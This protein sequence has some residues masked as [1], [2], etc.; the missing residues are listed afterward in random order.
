MDYAE[1]LTLLSQTFTIL[2]VL[3]TYQKQIGVATLIVC[4][5]GGKNPLNNGNAKYN[6]VKHQDAR[7]AKV[8]GS[9]KES[10]HLQGNH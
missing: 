8:G 10:K 3:Q 1:R 9:G 5:W 7:A 4:F 2:S 6:K